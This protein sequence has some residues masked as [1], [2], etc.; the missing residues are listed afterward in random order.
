M[1][2]PQD[3]LAL[4]MDRYSSTLVS[5]MPKKSPLLNW[6]TKN[7]RSTEGNWSGK[8]YNQPLE[9]GLNTN[10]MWFVRSEQFRVDETEAFANAMYTLRQFV[11]TVTLVGVD[12]VINDGKEAVVNYYEAK[13]KNLEKSLQLMLARSA[14]YDGTE[15]DGKSFAGLRH[16]VVDNPAL[17]MVGG[18]DRTRTDQEGRFWWRNK[19]FAKSTLPAIAS[20]GPVV[21]PMYRSFLRLSKDLKTVD[22]DSTDIILAG[23]QHWIDYNEEVAE[24]QMFQDMKKAGSGFNGIMFMPLDA[25]VVLDPVSPRDEA[26]YMLNSEHIYLR[27]SKRWL[28][29]LPTARPINQ[30]VT[31]ETLLGEGNFCFSNLAVQGVVVN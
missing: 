22:G 17:G 26:S 23:G 25:P 14:W 13:V 6:I 20:G 3:V 31:S 12:D 16:A 18:I 4:T 2:L 10:A 19:V 27:K 21:R 29:K 8:S 5:N 7:G 15:N 11:G 30:D 28:K 1:A 9:Y 24:K